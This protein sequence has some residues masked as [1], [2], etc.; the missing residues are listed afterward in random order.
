MNLKRVDRYSFIL[1]KN[2]ILK[3]VKKIRGFKPLIDFILV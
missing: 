3:N 1:T 2:T